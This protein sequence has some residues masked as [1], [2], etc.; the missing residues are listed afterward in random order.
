MVRGALFHGSS[1]SVCTSRMEK[2]VAFGESRAYKEGNPGYQGRNPDGGVAMRFPVAKCIALSSVL[3]C[4]SVVVVGEAEVQDFKP[5]AVRFFEEMRPDFNEWQ[6]ARVADI[7]IPLYR[8]DIREPAYYE[9]PVIR[10]S[11]GVAAGFIV[12]STGAHD[13]PI[14]QWSTNGHT[15]VRRLRSA[16]LNHA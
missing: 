3:V 2:L 6:D 13:Y 14:P 8:P 7:G 10:G 12:V 5:V 9:F 1:K 11:A 15:Y 16:T 4:L